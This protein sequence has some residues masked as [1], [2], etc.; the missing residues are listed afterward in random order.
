MNDYFQVTYGCNYP[1]DTHTDAQTYLNYL[2]KNADGKI[3]IYELLG[4][5]NLF[6]NEESYQ[7]LVAEGKI[8]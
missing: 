1:C 2:D 6:G 8:K 5:M 4:F 7:K 3:N